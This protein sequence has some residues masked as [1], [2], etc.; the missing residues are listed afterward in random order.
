MGRAREMDQ[1]ETRNVRVGVDGGYF[2]YN[3]WFRA[4][5]WICWLAQQF[6]APQAGPAPCSELECSCD[7]LSLIPLEHF[8]FLD[9]RIPSYLI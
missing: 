8:K 3:F 5:L 2:N 9:P 7:V 6:V 1:F 4:E